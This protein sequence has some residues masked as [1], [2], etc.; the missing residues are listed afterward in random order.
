MEV[1]Q[2]QEQVRELMDDRKSHE[3][4]RTVE[5]IIQT[6]GG[7]F[8]R[9]GYLRKLRPDGTLVFCWIPDL[10]KSAKRVEYLKNMDVIQLICEFKPH[11]V[12]SIKRL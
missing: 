12:I 1:K 7:E 6:K 11:Q 10:S 5:I 3:Q 9:R 8:P 4:T 2:L